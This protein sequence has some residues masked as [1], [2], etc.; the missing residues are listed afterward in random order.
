[1]VVE[2]TVAAVAIRDNWIGAQECGESPDDRPPYDQAAAAAFWQCRRATGHAAR[3]AG[4]QPVRRHDD[5][6]C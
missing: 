6:C 2:E 1:M 4:T 3:P 5:A